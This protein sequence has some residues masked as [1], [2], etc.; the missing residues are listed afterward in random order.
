MPNHVFSENARIWEISSKKT[1]LTI[2]FVQKRPKKHFW[3]FFS[4]NKLKTTTTFEGRT[5]TQAPKYF[6]KFLVRR[7]RKIFG[8]Y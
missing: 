7:R 3:S 1:F 8:V 4:Q 5:R 2:D 6:N